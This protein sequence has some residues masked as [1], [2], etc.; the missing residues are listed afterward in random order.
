MQAKSL[1]LVLAALTFNAFAADEPGSSP[2]TPSA[3]DRMN[4][5]RKALEAHDYN[6]AVS[7]LRTV[8]RSD[9]RNA[10]AHSLLGYS[11]RK[12]STPDPAKSFEHYNT[13]LKIDPRHKGAHEYI[14]EAYLMDKK[15]DQAEKHLAEL[16]KICGNR[17]CEEY[18]ELSKAIAAY[19]AKN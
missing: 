8:V 12:A 19:K 14:G 16:E 9:P 10:E 18:A 3:R 15:P 11:Y 7:E 5:A 1:L 6:K 17:S 4:N 2:A 13:A